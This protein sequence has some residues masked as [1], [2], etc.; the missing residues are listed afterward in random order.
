MEVDCNAQSTRNKALQRKAFQTSQN[1]DYSI[2][3]GA[4]LNTCILG[5]AYDCEEEG[6]Y[7]DQVLS[8]FDEIMDADC[9]T[10]EEY[11]ANF[12]QLKQELDAEKKDEIRRLSRKYRRGEE[13]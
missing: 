8:G 13:L 5:S 10:F 4:F 1:L 11:K 7:D 3:S 6:N 12:D 2:S 9:R